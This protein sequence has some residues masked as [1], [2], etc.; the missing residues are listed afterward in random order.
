MEMPENASQ[1]SSHRAWTAK[2]RKKKY[3]A[4]EKPMGSQVF[5]PN[6]PAARQGEQ[7]TERREH[8]ADLLPAAQV[9]R[10]RPARMRKR[11]HATQEML[12]EAPPTSRSDLFKD[13]QAEFW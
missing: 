10:E 2:L 9:V 11:G 1:E 12:L 4:A 8:H 13:K 3:P 7:R 5:P 6:F